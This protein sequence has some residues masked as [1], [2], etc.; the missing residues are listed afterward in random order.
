[1]HPLQQDIAGD[2]FGSRLGQV[3]KIFKKIG[4]E[5]LADPTLADS[6]I[7]PFK[8]QGVKDFNDT[9]MVVRGKFKFKPGTQLAIRKEIFR[10]MQQEFAASNIQFARKEVLVKVSGGA[11]LTKD[12]TLAA[13]A[14]AG[15][16]ASVVAP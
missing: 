15:E 9:G 8:S 7:E 1:M 6:F 12:Q 16:T 3:R 14:A 5:M 10:R 2:Q 11:A 4:L 13:A